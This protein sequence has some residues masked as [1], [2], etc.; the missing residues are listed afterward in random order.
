MSTRIGFIGT[1]IMGQ[2]MA[3]NILKAGYEIIVYNR[4]QEKTGPLARDGAKVGMSPMEVAEWSDV[5][6]LM[7]TGPEAIDSVLGD[8]DG[9]LRGMSKGGM[10]IN[11]STVA[12]AYTRSL[13]AKLETNGIVL[14]DAPVSGS[15]K[16]AED[17]T[18]IILA[19]GPQEKIK[20]LESVFLTMGKRI[21][22]CG[23]VGQGSGMKMAVNLLLAIMMAGLSEAVSLGERLGLNTETVLE[24]ILSGPLGCGLFNLKVDML[25]NNVF[26]PQF[27]L[28]HMA[29]DL[30]FI[31]DTA[32]ENG[33]SIQVGKAAWQLYQKGLEKGLGDQDVAVVKMMIDSIDN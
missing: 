27:P 7:L 14:I 3:R 11:M 17:G 30:G 23:E 26:P 32:D 24:T 6:I 20:R 10:I 25:K 15:R 33:I 2:P 29:K 5:V 19:G 13:A 4:T 31:M 12:P 21:V 22:Y 28:K 16:P 1:G 9:L 18:L 8:E